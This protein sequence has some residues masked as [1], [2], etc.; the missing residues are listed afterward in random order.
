MDARAYVAAA[1]FGIVFGLMVPRGG[2]DRK[3]V[4]VSLVVITILGIGA[5][6]WSNDPFAGPS[7]TVGGATCLLGASITRFRPMRQE[8]SL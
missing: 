8:A 6:L 1:V 7:M 2:D 5:W 4:L 3:V